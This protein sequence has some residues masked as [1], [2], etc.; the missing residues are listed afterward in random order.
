MS[1]APATLT[2]GSALLSGLS[3]DGVAD[4]P[5]AAG[6]VQM[7]ESSM[8][9]LALS[10]GIEL[11][12]TQDGHTFATKTSALDFSGNVLLYTTQIS[13]ACSACR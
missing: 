1:S 12:V 8:S 7:L 6:T 13:G 2:A 5:T 10:G 4:V 3:L 11:T 9:S